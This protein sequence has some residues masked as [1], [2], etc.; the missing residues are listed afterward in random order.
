MHTMPRVKA[1]LESGADLPAVQIDNRDNIAFER[2]SMRN[3]WGTI[4]KSP[5]TFL[6]V[7]AWSALRRAGQLPA[8]CADVKAW[9]R[10]VISV[11]QVDEEGNVVEG[12]NPFAA[13]VG[14]PI[15]PTQPEKSGTESR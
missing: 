9:M 10:Q 2:E 5:M 15:D 7:A 13:G 6:T 1:T 4:D 12:D 14:E 3:G 8:D 11:D